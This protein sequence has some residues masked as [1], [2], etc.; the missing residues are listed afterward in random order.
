MKTT[1]AGETSQIELWSHIQNARSELFGGASDRLE[2]LV[3]I[4]EKRSR[5]RALLN[6]GCGNGH[7]EQAAQKRG[8]QVI[9]VDPDPGSVERIK[10]MGIDARCGL[11][12]A[13]PIDSASLDV[14]VCSEVFEHL[15][16]DYLETGLKE[17][18]RVLKDGGILIGTVPYREDLAQNE[19]FCPDCHK[20]FHRWGHHQSF[21]E[22]KMR[23]VLGK[24]LAP[25]E[26]RPIYFHQWQVLDWKGKLLTV[27]RAA[28]S[29]FGAYGATANLLFIASKRE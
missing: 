8:W 22:S 11:I 14:V 4:A 20:T 26:V 7:L 15:F 21:D 2:K 25:R 12:H 3:R 24:Y 9:S 6:I 5:G 28:L 16:L 18:R 10:S 17:I 1:P 23:S 19:V 27:A 29:V 13:L